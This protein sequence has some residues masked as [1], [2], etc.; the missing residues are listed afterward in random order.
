MVDR[1]DDAAQKEGTAAMSEGGT[2]ERFEP[3]TDGLIAQLTASS[4]EYADGFQGD[5]HENLWGLNLTSF[6]GERMA[7]VLRRLHDAEQGR[8]DG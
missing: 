4:I 6:M 3:A 1:L 8:D 5:G 2:V 7:A